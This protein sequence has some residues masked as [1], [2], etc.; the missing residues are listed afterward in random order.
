MKKLVAVLLVWFLLIG[1]GVTIISALDTEP[2]PV[3]NRTIVV[4]QG[5]TLWDF[6]SS[7]DGRENYDGHR[8]INLIQNMNDLDSVDLEPGMTIII[9]EEVK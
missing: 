3:G 8:L 6:I 2:E 4:S 9:P 5:D 7:I 1:G